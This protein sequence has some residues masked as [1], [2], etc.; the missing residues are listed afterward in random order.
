MCK[1]L[2]CLLNPKTYQP[3]RLTLKEKILTYIDSLSRNKIVIHR[4]S[5][6]GLTPLNVGVKL[7][8]EIIGINNHKKLALIAAS[9]LGGILTGAISKV[10]RYGAILSIENFGILF[11]P[12]LKMNFTSLIDKHSIGKTLFIKWDGEIENNHLYFLTKEKGKEIDIKNLSHI[13]I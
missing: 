1:S 10:N 9:N 6:E 11:E 8:E 4:G 7:S 3:N 2:R 12:E 13:V 5:I